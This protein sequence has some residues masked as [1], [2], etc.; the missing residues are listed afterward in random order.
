MYV[1]DDGL[2]A[3][4]WMVDGRGVGIVVVVRWRGVG[5]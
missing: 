5:G 4:V 1:L 3:D 2:G